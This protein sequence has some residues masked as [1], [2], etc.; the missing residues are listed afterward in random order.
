MKKTLYDVLGVNNNASQ[1]EIKVAYQ[2]KKETLENATDHDSQNELKIVQQSFSILSD[3]KQRSSYDQR[4]NSINSANNSI[5]YSDVETSNGGVF[6]KILILLFFMIGAYEIYQQKFN[7]PPKADQS[8]PLVSA[9]VVSSAASY[10]ETQTAPA[11]VQAQETSQHQ[12]TSQQ[13]SPPNINDIDA[14]PLANPMTQ[15]KAYEG[16]LALPNP[17]A[18]V[19]CN[20]G[21]VMSLQGPGAFVGNKITTMPSDCSAYAVNDNVVWGKW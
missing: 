18:F 15:R 14:V 13:P 4:L 9:A 5:S 11:V 7:V 8:S 17:R 2:A 1:E 12:S 19:I 16:F 21:R 6:V 20:D 3:P 10:E